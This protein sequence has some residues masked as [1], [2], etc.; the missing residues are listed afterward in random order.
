MLYFL[1]SWNISVNSYLLN[2]NN[3]IKNNWR[4]PSCALELLP[5][6]FPRQLPLLRSCN[7][8]HRH[9]NLSC[10]SHH[11]SNNSNNNNSSSRHR[12]INSQSLGIRSKPRPRLLIQ[13]PP[14]KRHK[15]PAPRHKVGNSQKKRGSG[16]VN[17]G[18]KEISFENRNGIKWNKTS[19][20]STLLSIPFPS[21]DAFAWNFGLVL[22][23]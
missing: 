6:T 5:V 11:S 14:A 18:G 16:S 9:P 3:S 21:W 7:H 12:H 10:R 1:T 13:V 15:S 20:R 4:P 17:L 8:N 19:V 23:D 22:E 2:D